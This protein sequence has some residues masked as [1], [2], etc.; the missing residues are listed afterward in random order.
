MISGIAVAVKQSL[1]SNVRVYGVEP[2]RAAD[3]MRAKEAGQS[4]WKGASKHIAG[5][6]HTCADGLKTCLLSNN[7]PIVR[8]LVDHIFEV[9]ESAILDAMELVVSRLKL[10]IEPS[11]ATGVALALSS[12]FRALG[13]KRVAIVICGGNGDYGAVINA[14]RKKYVQD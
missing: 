11:A 12:Q 1:P 4:A 5:S 10:A 14:L 9:S 8:D 6:P 3:A 2:A 13:H 7:W